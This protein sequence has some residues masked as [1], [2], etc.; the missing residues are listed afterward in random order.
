MP[1]KKNIPCELI[2]WHRVYQLTR[3]L[4]FQIL[5]S[6]DR[7]DLIVAIGRGGYVPARILCDFL[8][9]YALTSIRVEHYRSG[10]QPQ[11]L[12]R[13]IYPLRTDASGQRVLVLDDVT[14]TGD[15]FQVALEHIREFKPEVIRTA[16]LHHKTVADYEPDWFAQKVATWRWLIYPWAV[17][18]DLTGFIEHMEAR[19]QAPEAIAQRLA[20]DHG[21]KVPKAMLQDVLRLMES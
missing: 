11:K 20:S 21:I 16:V 10:A 18:E 19:P 5:A 6:D 3:A 2:S 12:A 4:A 14:D 9:I 15:T 13:V 17:V 7:P 1:P 8:G